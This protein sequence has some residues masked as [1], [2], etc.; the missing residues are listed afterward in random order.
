MSLTWKSSGKPLHYAAVFL[1]QPELPLLSSNSDILCCD[2]SS[3][4]K[5]VLVR[6]GHVMSLDAPSH[7]IWDPWCWLRPDS[8][9]SGFQET[10]QA[11]LQMSHGCPLLAITMTAMMCQRQR[12]RYDMDKHNVNVNTSSYCCV[13]VIQDQTYLQVHFSSSILIIV[14][15]ELPRAANTENCNSTAI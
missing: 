6:P 13:L 2:A 8:S 3:L 15:L 14:E 11:G 5:L 12:S 4:Q 7:A 9:L 10:G 1:D